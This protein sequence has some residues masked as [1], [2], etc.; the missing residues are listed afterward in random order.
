MVPLTLSA[1]L[2]RIA[3]KELLT[4]WRWLAGIPPRTRRGARIIDLRFCVGFLGDEWEPVSEDPERRAW[5]VR[6]A[7]SRGIARGEGSR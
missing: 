3:S 2:E 6:P 7:L 1:Y 4:V 5:L